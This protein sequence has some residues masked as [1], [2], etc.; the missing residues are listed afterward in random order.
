VKL[1]EV[2]VD[3]LLPAAVNATVPSEAPPVVQLVAGEPQTKKLTVPVG[4]PPAALPCTVA[5]S[6]IEAPRTT[7]DVDGAV[8]MPVDA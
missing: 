4:P 3:V 8:V 2:A 1:A 5:T 7:D 6:V